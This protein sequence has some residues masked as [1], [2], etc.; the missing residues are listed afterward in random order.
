LIG[1]ALASSVAI[2]APAADVK[3]SV[4]H[5]RW[6]K[7]RNTADDEARRTSDFLRDHALPALMS[8]GARQAGVFRSAIGPDSPFL[9]M[10]TEVPS[11]AAL[12]AMRAQVWSNAEFTK[13]YAAYASSAARVYEREEV[14]LLTSFTG[15]PAIKPPKTREGKN[16]IFELR[17]YESNNGVTLAR[18]IRM[19]NDGEIGIF[20]RLGMQPVFFGETIAGSR[21]PNLA[22]MLSFENLAARERLWGKFV[23]DPEWKKISAAPELSDSQIV[24]NISNWILEP[25]DFS[26][27]R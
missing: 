2:P 7:M 14:S 18:K 16:N 26:P 22:Y 4:L 17:L 19:F 23:S 12:D 13:A 6:L 11:L 3:P 15:F 1:A 21:M 24:S 27:I 25:L 8:A 9:V 20:E 10:L 5:L